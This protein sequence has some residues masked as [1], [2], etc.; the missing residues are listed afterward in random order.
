MNNNIRIIVYKN[1]SCILLCYVNHHDNAYEWARKRRIENHPVT[2]ATQ[3]V[4]IRELIEDVT[5]QS[6]KESYVKSKVSLPVLFKN[7][8]KD[9]LLSIGVQKI[10]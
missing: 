8:K 9:D 2:G 4:E 3:I 10:G 5:I 7:L 1:Q 6:N